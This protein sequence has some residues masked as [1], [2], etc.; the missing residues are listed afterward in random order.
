[1]PIAGVERNSHLQPEISPFYFLLQHFDQE[2]ARKIIGEFLGSP[3]AIDILAIIGNFKP[4]NFAHRTQFDHMVAGRIFEE[5]SYLFLSPLVKTAKEELLAPHETFTLYQGVHP[6][7][8]AANHYGLG[9]GI[10]GLAI[11]DGLILRKGQATWQITGLCEYTLGDDESL[12][13]HD[14]KV[15]QLRSYL[16]ADSLMDN[17]QI[18]PS[19]EQGQNDLGQMLHLVRSDLRPLPVCCSSTWR[20]VYVVPKDSS[21]DWPVDWPVERV[22]LPLTRK[23][24]GGFVQEFIENYRGRQRIHR[25]F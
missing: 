5:V 10:Y 16:N 8:Q 13:S 18:D 11:P 6:D 25:L 19:Q 7:K 20:I 2:E 3:Q 22:N 15:S 21:F 14:R 24:F 9:E 1:M 12:N 23:Q 4:L 17:L